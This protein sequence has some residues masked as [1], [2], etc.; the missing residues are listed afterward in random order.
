MQYNIL[1]CFP[2]K[3]ERVKNE[4][5]AIEKTITL[6]LHTASP[7]SRDVTLRFEPY[8]SVLLKVDRHGH[9]KPIA[10]VFRPQTPRVL[11]DKDKKEKDRSRSSK[12]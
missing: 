8:Q 12:G 10:I 5:E 4:A 11:S 3:R 2:V 6:H 7:S 9:V 1:W